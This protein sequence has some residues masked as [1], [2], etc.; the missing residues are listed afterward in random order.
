MLQKAGIDQDY[1]ILKVY[2]PVAL[3]NIIGKFL[4][5]IMACRISYTIKSESLL[6]Q[7]HLRGYKGIL[8]DHAI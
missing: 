5:A 1:I 6:P 3:L 7:G 8:I 2:Y 4:E